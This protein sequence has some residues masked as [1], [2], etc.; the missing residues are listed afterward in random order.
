[1]LLLECRRCKE[2]IGCRKSFIRFHIEYHCESC[3]TKITCFIGIFWLAK[4]FIPT[5]SDG[6][7]LCTSCVNYLLSGGD[8]YGQEQQ[9]ETE[10]EE[11]H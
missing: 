9:E 1:M 8:Y 6:K 10:S 5:L 2:I 11:T 3:P 7:R 4:H